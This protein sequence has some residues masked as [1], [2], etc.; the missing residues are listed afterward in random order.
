[1]RI[2]TSSKIPPK[3]PVNAPMITPNTVPIA[4]VP[5]ATQN[6]VPPPFNTLLKMSRPKLSQPIR[7][8]KETPDSFAALS[9]VSGL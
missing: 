3:Y 4:T 2:K 8:E 1:M 6:V 9:I 7:C 5:S